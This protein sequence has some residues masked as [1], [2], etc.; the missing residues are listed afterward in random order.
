MFEIDKQ[1]KKSCI[2]KLWSLKEIFFPIPTFQ[3]NIF[4]EVELYLINLK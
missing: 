4:Q 1:T 3:R 2:D